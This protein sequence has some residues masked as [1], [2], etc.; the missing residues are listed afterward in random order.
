MKKTVLTAAVLAI[1]LSATAQNWEDGLRFSENEYEGTARTIAMGNAFTALGGD[2][3][4][5]GINPAGSAVARRSQFTVTPGMN[6]SIARVQGEVLNDGSVG[7]GNR[8][9]NDRSTFSMPNIGGMVNFNTGKSRG[10]KNWS[11]G[12]VVNNTRSY[13]EDI[14]ARGLNTRTS[15]FGEMAARAQYLY[16]YKPEDFKASRVYDNIYFS[17]YDLVNAFRAGAIAGTSFTKDGK[18][19]DAF[20][21]VTEN[22]T[23]DGR[24]SIGEHGLDQHFGQTVSGAKSDFVYNLAF[25]ISDVFFFGANVGVTSLNYKSNEF[26]REDAVDI[27]DV[28]TD[29]GTDGSTYFSSAKKTYSYRAEGTGVYGKFGFIL[30]PWRGLRI[31][32]AIQTP[33]AFT[34]KEKV[35]YSCETKFENSKFNASDTAPEGKFEYNFKAPLRA[36]FGV[37]YTFGKYGVFSAD[38]ELSNYRKMFFSVPGTS[39]NS[40]FDSANNSVLDYCGVQHY[41]RLGAEF[42][43]VDFFSVRLGYNLKTTGQTYET[44]GNGYLVKAPAQNLHT[45]S[46]GFG[47]TSGAF[48]ADLAAVGYFY[49]T[50]YITPYGSYDYTDDTH[51]SLTTESPIIRYRRNLV[52]VVATF[53]VRF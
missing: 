9:Q 6:I 32:A 17:D 34:I 49:P 15:A 33:T 8:L 24:I 45:A 23:A 14:I 31:G 48:F 28:K 36:N 29:F 41:L 10:L 26:L 42:K 19:E 25:N 37:A 46:F 39:D 12:F 47:F 13:N 16:G 40:E 21:G 18:T 27:E 20:V 22:S 38:Y 1:G 5:L 43:P 7:F 44:D 4:S 53:G 3:G 2:M 11:M 51:R 52:K 35:S 30:T 50:Q